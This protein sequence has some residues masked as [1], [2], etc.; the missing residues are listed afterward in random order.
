[1]KKNYFKYLLGAFVSILL[2]FALVYWGEVSSITND[3]QSSKVKELEVDF[4]NVGQGDAIYIRTPDNVDVLIDG[5][6]DNSILNELGAVMPFWDKEI[7]LMILSHPHSDHVAGLVEVLRRYKVKKILYT[8]VIHT[9]PDYLA[10]LK[11][12]KDRKIPLE[13]VNKK[14]EIMIGSSVKLELL[15]PQKSFLNQRVVNLNNTSI[16]A[17]LVY[18]QT[19]FLFTAD[20][21]KEVEQELLRYDEE[22]FDSNVLKVAHHGSESSSS[23]EFLLAVSPTLAV[24]QVGDEN[25]FNHPHGKTLFN[26]KN[27]PS[28]IY[29]TDTQ[30]RIAMISDGQKII[31][32]N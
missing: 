19:S 10:W 21:E 4:L 11:E 12:I 23:L 2:L 8:G 14:S 28:V 30:G 32:E 5:G 29:R 3:G 22:I 13:I 6:P 18:D 17:R 26:L 27:L 9:A 16:V 25:S 15:Y 1:M 20:I 7:D 31:V 24:I